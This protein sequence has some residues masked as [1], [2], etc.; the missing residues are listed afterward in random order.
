M[1]LQ[2]E[3]LNNLKV[4]AVATYQRPIEKNTE[5]TSKLTEE[6]FVFLP[7]M[8]ICA[9]HKKQET[10]VSCIFQ[11]Y[12]EEIPR[13]LQKTLQNLSSYLVFLKKLAIKFYYSI[14]IFSFDFAKKKNIFLKDELLKPFR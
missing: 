9:K 6:K 1:I 12:N 4:K 2:M 14:L 7:N 11:I 10:N 3:F 5:A 13:V 8:D